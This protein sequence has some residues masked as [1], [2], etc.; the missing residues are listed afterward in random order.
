MKTRCSTVLMVWLPFKTA[1][2][3]HLFIFIYLCLIYFITNF[4]VYKA[5]SLS[6]KFV[7]L[8]ARMRDLQ[9]PQCITKNTR[10]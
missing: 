8:V 4:T 6:G 9:I 10:T 7:D 5:A 3:L 1:V 2:Y